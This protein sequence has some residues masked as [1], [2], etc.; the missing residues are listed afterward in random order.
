[1]ATTDNKAEMPVSNIESSQMGSAEVCEVNVPKPETKIED[2]IAMAAEPKRP[3]REHDTSSCSQDL[4]FRSNPLNHSL[5]DRAENVSTQASGSIQPKETE[6]SQLLSTSGS[7]LEISCADGEC[8][9]SEASSTTGR[10]SASLTSSSSAKDA[11]KLNHSDALCDLTSHDYEKRHGSKNPILSTRNSPGDLVTYLDNRHGKHHYLAFSF[12]NDPPDDRTL[13]LF[14]RQIVQLGWSSPCLDRS[15]VPCIPQMIEA[16]YAIHAYLRLDPANVALIYCSNGKSRTGVVIACYLKFSG[17]VDKAAD[18]FSYF[19]S[20]F[21]RYESSDSILGNFPPS[22]RRF[23]H[24][25]DEVLSKGCFL[26]RKPLFLKAVALQGLPV[27]DEPCVDIWDSKQ[28]HVFSSHPEMWHAKTHI[29]S[30]R[31][32]SKWADEDG[33]YQ[34]N[35]V[36]DGDFLLLCRFGGDFAEDTSEHDPTKILFRYT[37]TTG[38]ICGGRPYELR[39]DEVD[40]TKRYKN[41]LEDDFLVTLLFQA[42]WEF[43]SEATGNSPPSALLEHTKAVSEICGGRVWRYHQQEMLQVGWDIIAKKHSARPGLAD[44]A[45]FCRIKGIHYDELD[46]L[47]RH[48]VGLALQLSNFESGLANDI[49]AC[50]RSIA[51]S[52]EQSGSTNVDPN[53]T[54]NVEGTQMME[55]TATEDIFHVLGHMDSQ[56]NHEVPSFATLDAYSNSH[57]DEM[58]PGSNAIAPDIETKGWMVPSVISPQKGQIMGSFLQSLIAENDKTNPDD[59]KGKKSICGPCVPYGLVSKPTLPQRRTTPLVNA[60]DSTFNLGSGDVVP[61]RETYSCLLHTGVPS[62]GLV[63]LRTESQRWTN[64]GGTIFEVKADKDVGLHRNQDNAALNEVQTRN[65]SINQEAKKKQEQ[66]WLDDQKAQAQRK[67]DA[68]QKNHPSKTSHEQDSM[69]SN[70]VLGLPLKDDPNFQKYFKMLK[71]GMP[72]DQVAHAMKRDEK[73]PAILDLDPTKPFLAQCPNANNADDNDLSL[74]ENPLYAKYFKMLR[75]GMPREQVLHAMKRDEKDPKILDLDPSQSLASQ[76]NQAANRNVD[77]PLKDDPEYAKYFKMLAMKLPMGAVK[78]A[79]LRDGK[80]PCIMDL[81]HER[82][83]QSQKSSAKETGE[84]TG[85]VLKDDPE[86][87][88]YFKMLAMKLPIG[89]VKNALVRDGKDPGIIDLDPNKSIASQLGADREE[90]DT[91]IPLKDDAEFSKYFKMEKMGLPRDAIRNA[92]IRDGKDPGIIDLDPTK[93]VAFQMKLKKSPEAPLPLKK[94]K[95]RRKKIYWNPIDPGKIRADSMWNI[96]RD[97]V[98]MDKLNYDQK[99]FEELFTE[100]ADPADRKMKTTPKKE[101]KKLVQVIDPKRSMNGG[102]VLARL[103]TDYRRIAE[104]VDKM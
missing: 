74:K 28:R 3:E 25:F 93:S 66:K 57:S 77:T 19:L 59:E 21:G 62:D 81:D 83:V 32:A 87:A 55:E 5:N 79:L 85:P 67:H 13:L 37:N 7:N 76:K 24:Q 47:S 95:V 96:V 30:S 31:N 10:L 63:H 65:V 99:E 38:C 11:L 68:S 44:V 78:N 35:A 40:L 101:S 23:F 52:E 80:D 14:R 54:D 18:G 17:M 12:K 33:F 42:D 1:L 86:Y 94:K 97:Y 20:K 82:S 46:E 75:M 36:L 8:T 15:S 73:D 71:I 90:H 84:D 27:E 50:L 72:K 45:M 88:K 49:L 98:A 4:S 102:I 39:F 64:E 91:G 6:H 34:V 103:K 104:Y 48:H 22:L 92:L 41:H 53:S 56:A 61:Q 26:N 16:C 2:Y 70:G 58:E 51:A 89:A 9:V 43:T 100:S 60:D 29:E 69:D